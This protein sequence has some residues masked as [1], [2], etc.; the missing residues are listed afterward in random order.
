MQPKPG[1]QYTIRRQI[2]KVFGAGFHVY[3]EQGELVAYCKQKAFRLREDF[4]LFADE[5]R[6]QEFLHIATR[7]IIDFSAAYDV[8]LP[9]GES[10]GS[11]KRKGFKSMFRD[12]WI[13]MDQNGNEIATIKEDSAGLAFLRRFID[14]ASI[15]SPQKFKVMTNSGEHIATFRQ[16]FNP[17]IFRMGIAIHEERDDLDDLVLL[18]G[19]VLIAAIE[20]RQ[21]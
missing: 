13:V 20:G 16:H 18:A 11:L 7:Q 6:T 12:S 17:F 21:G 19:G 8:K 1:E 3:G 4:R 14:F 15:I 10:I 9:S 2:F 5:E